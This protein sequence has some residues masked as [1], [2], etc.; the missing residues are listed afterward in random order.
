[1]RQ[2]MTGPPQAENPV[3]QDSIHEKNSGRYRPEAQKNH[4]A[5]SS[6]PGVIALRRKG[7]SSDFIVRIAVCGFVFLTNYSAVYVYNGTY[8]D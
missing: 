8:S 3:K 1:M 2:S 7:I 5:K 4:A 6:P